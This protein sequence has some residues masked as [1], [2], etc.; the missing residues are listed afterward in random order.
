MMLNRKAVRQLPVLVLASALVACGTATTKVE[1]RPASNI[2]VQESVGF[3]ITEDL[4][5]ADSTRLDYQQALVFLRDGQADRGITLLESVVS[6]A[7]SAT[8][9]RI[10]LGIAWHRKGELEQAERYLSE[11]L[12]INPGHPVALTEMGIVYRKTGRFDAA[13]QSYEAA[14]RVFPGYHHA[15]R[16]LAILCDLYLADRQCAIRQYEAYLATVPADAEAEMW[17]A[18]LRARAGGE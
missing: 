9:P 11:A 12:D 1:S 14:I 13:R 5:I 8:A 4:S 16:N 7:P 15:R 2:A 3:T 10:D 17:L 6:Q 18:D